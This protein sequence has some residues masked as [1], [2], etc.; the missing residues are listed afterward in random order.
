MHTLLLQFHPRH[1][2]LAITLQ[3]KRTHAEFRCPRRISDDESNRH[4]RNRF[5]WNGFRRLVG[6]VTRPSRAAGRCHRRL[7]RPAPQALPTGAAD[8]SSA[9]AA[10]AAVVGATAPALAAPIVEPIFAKLDAASVLRSRTTWPPSSTS[11][12]PM[13]SEEWTA[14]ARLPVSTNVAGD[15]SR[16]VNRAAPCAEVPSGDCAHRH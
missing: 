15:R 13:G 12:T 4:T 7:C 11:R 6:Y 3:G 14:P 9:P 5:R 16:S 10:S 1:E 8:T 2:G